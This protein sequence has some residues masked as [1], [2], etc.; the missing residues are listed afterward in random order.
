LDVPVLE[1][2]GSDCRHD[3]ARGLPPVIICPRS[4]L[5]ARLATLDELRQVSLAGLVDPAFERNP[6]GG[7]P[8]LSSQARGWLSDATPAQRAGERRGE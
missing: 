3:F 5:S 4:R 1:T 6:E 2:S 8:C 7:D